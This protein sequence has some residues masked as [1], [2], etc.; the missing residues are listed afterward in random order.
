MKF[1][2]TLALCVGSA[3]AAPQGPAADAP[4]TAVG[5]P[6]PGAAG[7]ISLGKF[8]FKLTS[9]TRSQIDILIQECC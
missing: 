5:A 4:P 2:Y 1:V 7:G 3:L 9:C 8:I 6:T